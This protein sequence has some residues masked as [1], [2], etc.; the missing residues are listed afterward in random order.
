MN[1]N[2]NY[3]IGIDTGTSSVG[4]AVIDE[5]FKLLKKNK[6]HLWGSRIFEEART[7]ANR[8]LNRSSRRRYNKRRERIFLLQSIMEKMVLEKDPTFFIRMKNSTF[9]VQED[10]KEVLQENYKDNYNLFSDKEFTDKDYYKKFPTIYHLRNYLCNSNKKE[11]PRLI[12]L[13]LHHIIKYR[14]NF[15]YEGKE[16][17]NDKLDIKEKLGSL[18]NHVFE[19]NGIEE[20]IDDINIQNI[21]ETLT[22]N[23][24]KKE[25]VEKCVSK[26]E[27]TSS[28]KSIL[29]NL[30]NG[31]LGMSCN[32]SKIYPFEKL[33][34]DDKDIIFKLS[35]EDFNDLLTKYETALDDNKLSVF[36]E[37]QNVYSW[38]ELQQ[39]LGEDSNGATISEIMIKKYE[40]H[41]KDL[42]QLKKI[43]K[44]YDTKV[45]H[46]V[47]RDKIN[48]HNYYNYIYHPKKASQDNFYKYIKKILLKIDTCEAYQLI[49]K[50]EKENFML[51]QNSRIYGSIPYQMQLQE[52]R[53]ILDK[54]SNYYPELM[55]NKDKII[56][57]LE[58]R[59]PYFYGPLDGNKTFGWLKKKIGKE[60]ERILPWNHEEIVDVDNTAALFIEKLKSMCTYLPSE[61]VMPKNSLTCNKYEVLSELNKIRING[62][63]IRR[64]TK[65]RIINDLFLKHKK[66]KEKHLIDWLN[67]EEYGE[68]KEITG[69][70]KDKEFASSMN[71]WIDFMNIFGEVND[72][73]YQLIEKI[74]NDVTIFNDPKILKRRL[75]K[76]YLLS[77]DKIEKI[78]K[79]NYKGWSSLSSKLVNG[80]YAD[81]RI[82]SHATILDV[83]EEDNLTLMEII[84]DDQLGYDQLIQNEYF[85]ENDN[86]SVYEEIDKLAC[87]PAIKKS[88]RQ[89]FLIIDEIAHF[90]GH[91]PTNVFIEFAREEKTK[92]RTLSRTTQL[93]QIYKNLE[94]NTEVKEIISKLNDYKDSGR[95]DDRLYLYFTQMGKCMYSNKPLDINR[96]SDYQIDH[97]LPRSL[98]KDDSLD[99]KVL[100][101][102][103]ENQRKL[104]DLVVPLEIRNRQYMIWKNLYDKRL[105]SKKKFINLTRSKMD[106][107]MVEKFINRQLVE[108]RQVIKHVARIISSYYGGTKV[109]AIRAN[110][111]HSYREK[112]EILKI[113][114]LNHF[115]HAHDA[116]IASI[117]GLFV[118]KSL[119][120]LN[121]RFDYNSYIHNQKSKLGNQGHSGFILN[122]MNYTHYDLD[123][124][125][126]LWEP[127]MINNINKVFDYKDC[128]VTKK[129]EVND[130]QLFKITIM[131]SDKNS[132]NGKTE[133]SFPVN[134]N[135]QDV[136]KYGGFTQISYNFYA[137]EGK[138]LSKKQEFIRRIVNIPLYLQNQSNE[139]LIQY[140][141]KEYKLNYVNIIKQ[142]KKN[143]L[144]EINGGL[145]FISSADELQ[146]AKQLI[147]NRKQ[148]IILNE[149]I[150]SIKINDYQS[151]DET[152]INTLYIDLI[153]KMFFHYPKYKK[154]AEKLSDKTE[155][156]KNSDI[157]IK[158]KVIIEIL[159]VMSAGAKNGN[160]K[161][162]GLTDRV[163]RINKIMIDLDKTVFY[164][165]SVTG[166]Y[167]KK[168]KL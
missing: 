34:D 106:D 19:E 18:L 89:T 102:S 80:L 111:G 83:M 17:I 168:E 52:L 97:I 159:N 50:I 1:K 148:T 92:K 108:T 25:K 164:H 149:I 147:L 163:G 15:L 3:S 39:I 86:I 73:N 81:N 33:K 32:F 150:K 16:F 142:I 79:L 43:I 135:R 31:V 104:D 67:N 63:L 21:I 158:C 35:E 107:N 9:L 132:K 134:K 90:M 154:I 138:K 57:I 120:K 14:G 116:Y 23:L 100:V 101:I 37:I 48:E 124:G 51:K 109:Y 66:V 64:D 113:R 74:A 12:Y 62:K 155:S 146:N 167:C 157:D 127:E 56:K 8:R 128:Y 139:A 131:P 78:M 28:L 161:L 75:K 118:K 145:F 38:I 91:N 76:V 58:F 151:I 136:Q 2:M 65:L 93:E 71:V 7:A 125:E 10:K 70:Q 45:Y 61:P 119:P 121:G 11:D 153:E 46:E 49:E 140:V 165:Q 20:D 22:S 133:A 84:N 5:Q 4:W 29:T 152:Q 123:T 114:E 143:Q 126:I 54:Q 95:M 98:I 53:M 47:F 103:S 27:A 40:D 156:F 69:Y 87:S 162:L 141:E 13:A 41:K 36:E 82:S 110:L 117:I 130:G 129:L 105:I 115:H 6:N 72:E 166:I 30:F 44:E 68:I 59:I 122:S 42:K 55:E 77:E 94:L 99:N 160:L 60:D 137:I 112:Y 26:F 88:I 85:K 144:V 96:L 24:T